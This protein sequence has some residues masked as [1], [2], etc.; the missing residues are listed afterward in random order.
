PKESFVTDRLDALERRLTD[1]VRAA[2]EAGRAGGG[3]VVEALEDVIRNLE[4]EYIE[5]DP[6]FPLAA[7]PP[8]R[9]GEPPAG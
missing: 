3:S 1:Q 8:P 4:S 9:P 7:A 6:R 2:V 5:W